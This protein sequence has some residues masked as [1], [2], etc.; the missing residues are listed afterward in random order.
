MTMGHLLPRLIIIAMTTLIPGACTGPAGKS[1]G[2]SSADE[3]SLTGT[4]QLL[5]GTLIEGGDTAVTDYTTGI[6]M[7]K[8]INGT[9]FAFLNHDLRHGK[10][11][12]ASFSAGGGRYSLSGSDYTEYL[13]YCSAREWEGNEFHFTI[14]IRHD[15]LIQKGIEK[16]EGIG[17][18]RLNIEVYRRVK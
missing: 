14:E 2:G 12:T 15:T 16:I 13:E 17:V 18:D 8:I 10:D 3:A 11:S 1:A 5:S 9:H 6:S 7:V 4:W